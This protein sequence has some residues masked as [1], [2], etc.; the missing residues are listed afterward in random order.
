VVDV[1]KL[2]EQLLSQGFEIKQGVICSFIL[3][4]CMYMLFNEFSS[5]WFLAFDAMALLV[6]WM[7]LSLAMCSLQSLF[8]IGIMNKLRSKKCVTETVL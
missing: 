1:G 7:I 4:G 8:H 6:S 2:Q 3:L 5:R